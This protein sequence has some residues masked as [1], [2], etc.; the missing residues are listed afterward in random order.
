M[1]I[2][3]KQF[4]YIRRPALACMGGASAWACIN[5]FNSNCPELP[6]LNNPAAGTDVWKTAGADQGLRKVFERATYSLVDSGH[7]THRGANAAQRLNLE[8]DGQEVQLSHPDGSV[9]S[10]LIGY[11]YGDQLRNPLSATPTRNGKDLQKLRSESTER[12]FAHMNETGVLRRTH[13]RKRDNILKRLLFH[14]VGFNL[15]PLLR[16]CY[17]IGKPRTLQWSS[18]PISLMRIAVAAFYACWIESA[19][20]DEDVFDLFRLFGGSALCETF[21]ASTTSC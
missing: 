19:Q 16:E 12:C 13:L 6:G 9:N 20:A 21:R 17:G 8:F 7:G 5:A 1:E 2:P 11:G 15:A 3:G 18:D 14:A 4:T 10:H